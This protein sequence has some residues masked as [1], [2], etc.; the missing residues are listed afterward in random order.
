MRTPLRFPQNSSGA[1]WCSSLVLST[2]LCVSLGPLLVTMSILYGKYRYASVSSHSRRVTRREGLR[3]VLQISLELKHVELLLLERK[4][5]GSRLVASGR[6]PVHL[7][8]LET[9]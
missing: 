4:G 5:V 3:Q 6:V 8:A 9:K 2:S 1:Q 7:L